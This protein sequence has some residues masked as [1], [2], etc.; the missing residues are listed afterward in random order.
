MRKPSRSVWLNADCVV[1]DVRPSEEYEAGHL[2]CA[3][4]IPLEDLEKRLA[5]LPRD[6]TVVAYCRGPYCWLAMSAVRV[7]RGHGYEAL[8]VTPGFHELQQ[9]GFKAT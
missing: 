8:R 2:A 6:K 5:E 9:F 7:L 1:L 3:V 4:S